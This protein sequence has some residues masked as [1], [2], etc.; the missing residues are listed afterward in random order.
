MTNFAHLIIKELSFIHHLNK[1]VLLLFAVFFSFAEASA[2]NDVIITGKAF[3]KEDSRLP[4]PKL[5]VINKRTNN[6]SFAD[7]EGKFTIS[8]KQQD[9]ILFST[10]GF[11]VKKICMKDSLYKNRYTVEVPMQKLQYTLKEI[12]VFAT[13]D[14]SEI[15]KD[16][17]KLGVKHDYSAQSVNVIESPITALYERFSKFARSKQKVAEWENEDLKRDIL[18]DLFH[19]YVKH[20]IIDLTDDE[21]DAFIKYLNFSDEYMQNASQFELTMAIKGKYE[22]FKYRWK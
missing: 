20:D 5:M 18:K 13:R 8:A 14:L 19:L 2:Q 4:L 12:S 3:D 6:G 7:A 9:T 11:I 15:Q 16:I 1:R 21:F 10:T 22:S 17:N